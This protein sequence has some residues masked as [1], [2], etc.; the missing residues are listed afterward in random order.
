MLLL[1]DGTPFTTDTS[2]ATKPVKASRPV[3]LKWT[4]QMHRVHWQLQPQ[5]TQPPTQVFLDSVV[6]RM[7]ARQSIPQQPVRQQRSILKT[8]SSQLSALPPPMV[9][10]PISPPAIV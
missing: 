3:G 2:A 1:D 6:Q 9:R 5:Q 8:I 4:H 7:M 10:Q